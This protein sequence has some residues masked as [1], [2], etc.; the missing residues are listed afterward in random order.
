[1]EKARDSYNEAVGSLERM[2][3][4]AAR[5]FKDLGAGSDREVSPV[6]PVEVSLRVVDTRALPEP[7]GPEARAGPRETDTETS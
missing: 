2:V 5:R 4:P 1:L 3:L 7:G 6:R